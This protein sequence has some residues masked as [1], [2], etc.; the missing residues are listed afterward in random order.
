MAKQKNQ[1]WLHFA[2]NEQSTYETI[3]T[4]KVYVDMVNDLVAGMLLSQI[5]Y[6]NLPDKQGNDSK[7]RVQKD[8]CL[9]LAKKATD[10][11]D[12]IRIS[13][14]QVMRATSILKNLNLVDTKIFKF[15]GAPTTHFKLNKNR[16]LELHKKTLLKDSDF[17]Q[18]VKSN[19]P[20]GQ[21]GNTPLGK[22]ELAQRVKSL[23]Y[24]TTKNTQRLPQV[25]EPLP[26]KVVELTQIELFKQVSS[27]WKKSTTYPIRKTKTVAT[28]WNSIIGEV[29]DDIVDA[30]KA[31]LNDKWRIDHP[32]SKKFSILLKDA[33]QVVSYAEI[34][35]RT[36]SEL[37]NINLT[38]NNFS[39]WYDKIKHH[40]PPDASKLDFR[41]IHSNKIYFNGK[42]DDKVSI[43]NAFKSLGKVAVL[44]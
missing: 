26:K 3:S 14:K 8:G 42:V 20:I 6:W 32:N 5:V 35:R 31:F 22:I 16:L 39:A 43:V 24:I 1:E 27:I 40:L 44:L 37:Q 33:E 11:F 30:T 18:R 28:L 19:L 10:W 12:E 4:K 9:W 25:R 41:Y 21:N 23:T 38:N 17:T 15:D 2:Y 34:H 7:L 36:Q 29:Q 13:N